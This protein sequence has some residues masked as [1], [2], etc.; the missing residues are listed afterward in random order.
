[1]KFGIAATLSASLTFLSSAVAAAEI[2]VMAGDLPPMIQKDG[3]GREAEIISTVLGHCGHSVVFTV[4]PLPAIGSRLKKALAMRWLPYLWACQR[5]ARRRSPIS[6]IKMV[7][8][9]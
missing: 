4:Q 6:P 2:E 7:F 9:I 3:T 5:P 1:M 8:P